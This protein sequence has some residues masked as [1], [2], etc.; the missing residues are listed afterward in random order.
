MGTSSNQGFWSGLLGGQNQLG[1]GQQPGQLIPVTNP[2]AAFYVPPRPMPYLADDDILLMSACIR[3][4]H[5]QIE[6]EAS[7]FCERKRLERGIG[8]NG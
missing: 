6:G 4:G 2:G 3:N 5:P 8:K 1:A 7:C